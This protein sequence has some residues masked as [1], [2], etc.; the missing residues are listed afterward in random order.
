MLFKNNTIYS[1]ITDNEVKIMIKCKKTAEFRT[2]T[3]KTLKCNVQIIQPFYILSNTEEKLLKQITKLCTWIC[4]QST[5][6]CK[7][8]HLKSSKMFLQHHNT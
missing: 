8:L 4:K 2:K 3:N 1:T 6:A 7:R 5:A